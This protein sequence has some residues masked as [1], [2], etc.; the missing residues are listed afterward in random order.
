MRAASIHRLKFLRRDALNEDSGHSEVPKT[1]QGDSVTSLSTPHSFVGRVW[2][3]DLGSQTGNPEQNSSLVNGGY[4]SQ[5]SEGVALRNIYQQ[6][7]VR[8]ISVAPQ[9]RSSWNNKK[10][11][12]A[13]KKEICDWAPTMEAGKMANPQNISGHQSDLESLEINQSPSRI[14]DPEDS[15]LSTPHCSATGV[16]LQDCATGAFLQDCAPELQDCFYYKQ[17]NLPR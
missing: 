17:V 7:S 15:S 12:K 10:L 6:V 2:H 16:V 8:E 14:Q 5:Q 9:S 13:E 1:V 4:Q 3:N 11:E